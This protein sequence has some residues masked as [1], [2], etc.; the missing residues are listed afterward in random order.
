MTQE[1]FGRPVL[2]YSVAIA[3][4]GL[5]AAPANATVIVNTIQTDIPTSVSLFGYSI[6]LAKD[7]IADT[8]L[9][10]TIPAGVAS[11]N[12]GFQPGDVVGLPTTWNQVGPDT[13]N[14]IPT[15]NSANNYLAVRFDVG[16]G[17]VNYG[18]I[19]T[20]GNSRVLGYAYESDINTN[21]TVF[22]ISAVPE[23]ASLALLASGMAGVAALR[24]RRDRQATH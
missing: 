14:K 8:K 7:G 16:S 6:D 21:I 3:T 13:I 4:A 18:F 17:N 9:Q 24:R 1:S 5:Y 2:A 11:S 23:P 22:D 15:N 10:V 19:E 12:T 20:F